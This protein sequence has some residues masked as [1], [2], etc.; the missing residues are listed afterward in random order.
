MVNHYQ[1]NPTTSLRINSRG[2][3]ML[4]QIDSTQPDKPEL[5]INITAK[6]CEHIIALSKLPLPVRDPIPV[7]TKRLG[8]SI[9]AGN[10]IP[11]AV[12]SSHV[13][14]RATLSSPLRK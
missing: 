12:I 2:L 3:M 14:L 6:E 5:C 1:I 9:Q 7:L 13:A 4:C 11:A 10:G 8:E